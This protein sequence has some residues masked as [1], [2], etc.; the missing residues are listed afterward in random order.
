MGKQ[1]PELNYLLKEVERHYGRRLATSTDFEALSV[2]IEREIN[3]MISAST[4]K[5]MWGYVSKHPVPRITTLDIL[6]RY[7]GY[8]DF[9]TFR[10][11]LKN[12]PDFESS[13]FS[14]KVIDV[15]NLTPGNRVQ[16]CWNPNRLVVL[17]YLGNFRFRV[18]S[19]ENSHLLEDDEFTATSFMQDYP[20]YIATITR[21]SETT[22][23]YIAGSNSG[24]T[25]VSLL[26]QI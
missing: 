26:D 24:L 3:E 7:I 14:A 15:A 11:S 4:L 18:I 19:S 17:E 8:R 13:F 21:G 6:A 23:S 5:R 22:P 1:I 12:Q 10:N 2:L 20:L 25:S 9:N 16:I